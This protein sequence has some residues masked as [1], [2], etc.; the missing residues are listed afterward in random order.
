MEDKRK[1]IAAIMGAIIAYIQME[2]KAN[3]RLTINN[4]NGKETAYGNEKEP[5]KNH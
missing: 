1:I 2:Q 5:I 3:I 4:A